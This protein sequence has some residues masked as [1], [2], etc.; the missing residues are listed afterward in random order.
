[1]IK[2][3]LLSM[4][5]I[6]LLGVSVVH[7]ATSFEVTQEQRVSKDRKEIDKLKD[8]FLEKFKVI[9]NDFY[10]TQNDY[11]SHII[12]N[13]DLIPELYQ[14]Q[15]SEMFAN[16]YR[17]L[18]G[19]AQ[20]VVYQLFARNKDLYNNKKFCM[21]VFSRYPE[22]IN[23]ETPK[24]YLN[25]EELITYIIKNHT[26]E[27]GQSKE[28]FVSTPYTIVVI[29]DELKNNKKVV[30]TL[31]E[32]VKEYPNNGVL[33]DFVGS[34]MYKDAEFAEKLS[35][36]DL[37]KYNLDMIKKIPNTIKNDKKISL[38]FVKN[39][40]FETLR[41]LSKELRDNKEFMLKCLKF[42]VKSY[43]YASDR[44]KEDADIQALV[45]NYKG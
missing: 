4:V 35:E 16:T 20:A 36:L 1:M 6:G 26:I 24:E 37:R 11:S 5:V 40:G 25:N 18:H 42:D 2:R 9:E 10:N 13:G 31:L 39:S 7:A 27:K 43:Y 8:L 19:K 38:N 17:E 29:S 44:L 23:F 12:K 14:I 21:K 22:L 32:T 30:Y 45:K 41:F 3:T 15:E 34:E 33:Y 28:S